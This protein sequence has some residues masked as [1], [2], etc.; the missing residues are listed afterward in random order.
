M[1]LLRPL[2]LGAALLAFC[3]GATAQEVQI[4]KNIDARLPQLQGVQ[5]VRKT[6]IPGIYEIRV[7]DSEIYYTDA[8]GEYLIQGSVY[9]LRNQRN[10]TKER[11]DLLTAVKWDSLPVKDAI[12]FTRGNGARKLAVFADP[13]CGYCKKFERDLLKLD[14]VTVHVFQIGILS[15]DSKAKNRAIW[16]SRDKGQAWLDWMVRNTTP[17]E[18]AAMCD[19]SAVTRNEAFAKKNKINSTPTLLFE[20]GSRQAGAIP[21]EELE[22][23]FASLKK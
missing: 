19:A 13:N 3:L 15:P 8:K 11:E 23:Q 9:D 1:N 10:L 2:A 22:Q 5:E 21:M 4:K 7:Q 20:D 18:A 14:N 6:P 12:T 16:C 17:A